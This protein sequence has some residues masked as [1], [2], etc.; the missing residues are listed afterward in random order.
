MTFWFESIRTD[1]LLSMLTREKAR[2]ALFHSI[3]HVTHH[4]VA[5]QTF[6]EKKRLFDLSRWLAHVYIDDTW[7]QVQTKQKHVK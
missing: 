3:S 6:G 2:S 7:S 4:S 1:C 5:K